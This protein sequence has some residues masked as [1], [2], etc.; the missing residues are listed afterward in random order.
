ME[1]LKGVKKRTSHKNKS[2]NVGFK[3]WLLKSDKICEPCWQKHSHLQIQ[4]LTWEQPEE[5]M[6][7]R[8]SHGVNI[9]AIL[10]QDSGEKLPVKS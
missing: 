7:Q 6:L 2:I 8:G 3:K 5:P 4:A 10:G 1:R 9:S